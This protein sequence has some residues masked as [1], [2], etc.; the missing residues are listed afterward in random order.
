MKYQ[1]LLSFLLFGQILK[2]Q[3][4]PFPAPNMEYGTIYVCN[5]YDC[6]GSGYFN[7]SMRYEGPA[8]LCGLKWSRF[9]DIQ[10]PAIKYFIRVDEGKYYN[11]VNCSNQVLMYDFSKNLGDTIL[12]SDLGNLKVTEVGVYTL[13]DGSTRKKMTLT[14]LAPSY[15]YTY[16]WVDGIGDLKA[17]FFRYGDFEGGHCELICLRDS[18]GIYYHDANSYKDCDSLLCPEPTS[19]FDFSCDGKTFQFLNQSL[20]ATSYLWEFG[21]GT[22]STEENPVHNYTTAGCFKVTLAAKSDCLPQ[23]YIFSKYV[24]VDA[25]HFWKPMTLPAPPLFQQ[26]Q[27]L[28]STQA[29][30]FEGNYLYKSADG[31]SHWDT[32]SYP[33]PPRSIS[34]LSFSDA[35]HGMVVV[36]IAG[37]P[38]YK[39]I[40][41][42]NDG[43]VQW[44][45]HPLEPSSDIT[46]VERLNDSTGVASAHYQGVFVT[47][48]GGLTWT[49]NYS[50]NV[51]LIT[52]FF[53]AGNGS[54]YFTGINQLGTPTTKFRFG[55]STDLLNWEVN[56]YTDTLLVPGFTSMF[57]TSPQKGFVCGKKGLIKTLD[58]GIKWLPVPGVE[59]YFGFIQFADSLHGWTCGYSGGIYGTSDGGQTWQQQNCGQIAENTVG[60]GVRT[61]TQA[62][63]V[64]GQTWHVFQ[65]TPTPFNNCSV[66]D[67]DIPGGKNQVLTLYP[68]PTNTS[69]YLSWP[70]DP[71]ELL[72]CTLLNAQGRLVKYQK[73]S[74][75]SAVSVSDL[76]AGMYYVQ[77]RVPNTPQTYWGKIVVFKH[78]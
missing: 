38:Y 2:A 25:P 73:S 8:L 3:Y 12:T 59:G 21:D 58:G 33:G 1:L 39:E 78:L 26:I 11:L 31:G 23:S 15:P 22:T 27:Y 72:E 70:G 52:D 37:S 42:T 67:I 24:A 60:L 6:I 62:Q 13:L 64:I 41:W 57:F 44:T 51:T 28:D 65:T 9:V 5:I 48:N 14:A 19:K 77:V 7:T 45:A 68:N 55:K 36:K 56:Q 35:Q 63:A 43:G 4:A 54:V 74:A 50:L 53:P 46:A 61:A 71:G 47:K 18:S 32:V 69:F 29:W 66:S 17:G 40:L 20:D 75:S 49:N 34:A 16:T 30:A 10:T 76:P